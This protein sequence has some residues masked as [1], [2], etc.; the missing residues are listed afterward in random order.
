MK[1][2]RWALLGACLAACAGAWAQASPDIVMLPALAS[3]WRTVVGHWEG[4]A[5]LTGDTVAAPKP[6][7]E[8][9]RSGRAAAA[10]VGKD[11]R[12][13]A[14]L[15]DW[16]DLWYS[17]LRIESRQPLDL[18][19][20]MGGTLEF[21]LDVVEL[22]KGGVRVKLA[23]GEGCERSVNLIEPARA[24]AGKGW[25]RMALA[26]SCFAR[27]GA[28]FSKVSLP[29]SLEGNG[30]GRVSIAN[31]RITRAA[32]RGI[33]CP[34]Y[35]T[36]AVTAA[37]QTE[38]FA[39]DWWLPLHK[40]KLEEKGKL[41]AAGTGPEIVFI[42][43]SITQGWEKEGREV[44]QRHYAPRR[45]L[46]LGFG[47]ERTENVLWRLQNGEIDDI[48]PKAAVLMIG[49]NNSGRDTPAAIAAGIKRLL[50]EIRQRLPQTQVLLLAIFPRG[51]K[52]D[53]YLR[54][55]NERVNKMIAGY[56]DD[57]VH[58]LDINAELLNADG[59]LGK[60]VM[61]DLLHP[62]AKGYAIWQRAM[63]PALQRLLSATPAGLG[64][65]ASP[66]MRDL[67]SLQLSKLMSPGW[68]LGNSLE[69][70]DKDTP[71]V[72]GSSRFNEQAWG[73]PKVTQDLLSA[74]KAAGFK[75]VRI[76]ASWKQYADA[77]DNISPLWMARVKEVVGYARNAG[78]YAI[79]NV[80]WDGGWMQPTHAQQAAANARLTKFWTQIG[81]AFKD[82]DDH[83]LFAG[84][85]E[86]MVD[87]DY[88]P[89]TAE[90]CAVQ[91]GFNQVFV[92]AVR[93]TG[94]N[95]ARRHLVV[96]AFNTNVDHALKCNA[97]LPR[98]SATSRLFMEVHYYDPF[99]FTINE[100]SDIWQWG[101]I[102]TDKAAT[103]TWADEAHVDRQFQKLKRTFVDKG[104]PVL[105][106]EY[107][108]ML[109]KQHDPAG[110]YRK[111][112]DQ[113][114]TKSAFQHGLVPVYWDNGYT[115]DLQMGLFNR[116]T[117]AQAFADV[118]AAIVGATQ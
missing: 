68:N 3:A 9:A 2:I 44:W 39:I 74:V 58:F 73:N 95:N 38:W 40:Q 107:G 117:G 28:D 16:Q 81:D 89:P 30:T 65:G 20:Y 6:T 63:E 8:W 21:D 7:A 42:G 23:C 17:T 5:E 47:G 79:V 37:M 91:N 36:E 97:T 1:T 15:F 78:L 87:G 72:W 100:K 29:F 45:A 11:G 115:A 102:A 60:D 76:P 94:G 118:I 84:T 41:V 48:A 66:A 62:N 85:N 88:S 71:Y 82:H 43:D 34:D 108:A 112:W 51:E 52:P 69:A 110:T 55:V 75:S 24:A 92:D 101:S 93:A 31:V 103:E 116:A 99:N 83:L 104:V 56:A 12:R 61:P 50:D 67:T 14:M 13:E 57:R 46:S 111:Y 22:A 26:M 19:P 33:D 86:V 25:R 49:T 114:I 54:G 32:K 27:E 4:Q 98:D 10:A 80:H 53:D 70:I 105:L 35:R 113:T 90:L 59:T 18:R 96:Q 77:Q 106:G 64:S 109:R